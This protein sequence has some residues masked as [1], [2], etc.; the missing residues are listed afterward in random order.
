[1]SSAY[2]F[3]NVKIVKGMAILLS[4]FDKNTAEVNHIIV[5]MLHRIAWDCKM[6]SMIFQATIFRSFQ[7]I[8]ESKKPEHK[9]ILNVIFEYYKKKT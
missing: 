5:K 2:R 7:R 4:N 3:V 9:V 6:P 8:F 1:M